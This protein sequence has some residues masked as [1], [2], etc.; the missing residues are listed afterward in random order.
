MFQSAQLGPTW[1]RAVS[2]LGRPILPEELERAKHR[3]DFTFLIAPSLISAFLEPAGAGPGAGR[4]ACH[5]W[6]GR[7]LA[8]YGRTSPPNA[9][10]PLPRI[11]HF[12][13]NISAVALPS[14][15]GARLCTLPHPIFL[16]R[17]K[18]MPWMWPW[19]AAGVAIVTTAKPSLPFH[20]LPHLRFDT[21]CWEGI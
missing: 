1:L 5:G 4:R 19:I 15:V 20:L 18:G 14:R 3:D 17:A 13:R 8:S 9:W 6:A 10:E 7:H 16:S 11:S 12:S 21:I 2:F